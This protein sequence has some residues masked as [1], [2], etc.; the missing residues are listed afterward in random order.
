VLV[1]ADVLGQLRLERGLQHRLRQPGQQPTG[2]DQVHPLDPGSGHR[3]LGELLLIDLLR[4]GQDRLG[5]CWSSPP[6][7]LGVSGQ[8]S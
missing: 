7:K 6:S 1:V 2:A 5:D 3:I 8:I 4:H